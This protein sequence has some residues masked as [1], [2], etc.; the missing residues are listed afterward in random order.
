M[1]PKSSLSGL[2][3]QIMNVI[4]S[5]GKATA[6]DIQAA[7]LPQRALTDSTIRTVLSRLEEKEYLKHEVDGRAFVYRSI[8]PP[9][10]LAVRAVKQIVDRFC[11]GSV[12]S[13]LVGMVER[14]VV[15]AA[16][17]QRIVDQFAKEAC[18]KPPKLQER[19][20]RQK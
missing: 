12:E 16:E 13:L 18:R 15:D 17:L 19:K 8:E 14:E 1:P 3:Q 4:W 6:A 11:Q 2:E 7:L 20:D 5:L 10:S 9:T